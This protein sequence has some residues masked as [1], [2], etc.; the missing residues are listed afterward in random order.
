MSRKKIIQKLLFLLVFIITQANAHQLKENYLHMIYDSKNKSALLT[1]EIETRVLE[2]N[3]SIDDNKNGIIS[4]K[5]LRAHK[6][7]IFN[8]VQ[9]HFHLYSYEK[10]IP[11]NGATTIFHRYQDQTYMQI[12]KTLHD[13]DLDNL[14]L[15]YDM[16]FEQE[17]NHKLLIHLDDNRGDFIVDSINRGYNFSSFKMTQFMRLKLFIVNGVDHILD[18][19]DHLLFVLMILIPSIVILH[20]SNN[21][22]TIKKSLISLLK[23]VSTFSLAHSLTLF[24]SGAGFW[25]PN[26]TFIESSIALSIFVVAA[27]NFVKQYN[28]VNKKIVFLFGLLHGFGF[29]NVL[30]IAK[31]DDTFSFVVALFGFNFGV[32]LGQIF[33]IT[34]LL[35]ILYILAKLKWCINILRSIAFMAMLI[36]AFWFLQRVGVV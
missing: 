9:Q 14:T 25:T 13:I 2:N 27:L 10:S 21:L 5:E 3:S 34:L 26:I 29:A 6:K 20:F 17:K 15:K 23:I 31:I 33:V 11:L 1:L 35:P 8:Y 22:V 12:T 32:E 24:I 7:Y 28:H 30:E 19:L 4:F 18:G 36:S 16:F